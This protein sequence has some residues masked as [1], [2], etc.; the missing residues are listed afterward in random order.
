[1]KHISPTTAFAFQERYADI[2][3]PVLPNAVHSRRGSERQ[4]RWH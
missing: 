3:Q 4:E 2:G 1:M